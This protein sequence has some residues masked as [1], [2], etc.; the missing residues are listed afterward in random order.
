MRRLGGEEEAAMTEHTP[1]PV[2]PGSSPRQGKR[3]PR[4]VWLIVAALAVML[5]A[6]GFAAGAYLLPARSSTPP[7]TAASGSST[8]P[9]PSKTASP[10]QTP[11]QAPAPIVL[12]DCETLWPERYA[13]AK[14]LSDGYPQGGIKYDDFGDHRFTELFGPAAQTALSQTT[15]LRGCGYP[16]SLETY[17][18]LYLT[19]LSGPPKDAFLAAL[20]A[21]GD[22]VESASGKSTVFVWESPVE[23]GHWNAAYTVHAFI[24]DIWIAGFGSDPAA[25]YVP[26]ITAAILEA[27]PTLQ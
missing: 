7:S 5:A 16:S 19:E 23:G 9:A 17:T 22:F 8:S 20:R 13:R 3:P 10:T 18:D 12:P 11:E 27:N 2:Q 25:D 4:W 1:T 26:Q 21:D 14:E 24:G 15:Q 6:G